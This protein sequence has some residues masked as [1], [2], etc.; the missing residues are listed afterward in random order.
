M[1]CR[2]SAIKVFRSPKTLFCFYINDAGRTC[3][4]SEHVGQGMFADEPGLCLHWP[5]RAAL[6][7]AGMLEKERSCSSTFTD[8]RRRE[9][10]PL[11][12]KGCECG[13]CPKR[14]RSASI[15]GSSVTS[16]DSSGSL[17]PTQKHR[18][19][20]HMHIHRHTHTHEQEDGF[21]KTQL[22]LLDVFGHQT[23][24][25]SYPPGDLC[26]KCKKPGFLDLCDGLID[27]N[28]CDVGMYFQCIGFRP[29]F[30]FSRR[31]CKVQKTPASKPFTYEIYQF[32]SVPTQ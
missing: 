26:K 24:P 5:S 27:G 30:H 15:S 18:A 28:R 8:L 4:K 25:V 29:S 20:G 21:K 1:V 22:S 13:H 14:S 19:A 17:P 31:R 12:K 7:K 10:C 32:K 16:A 2:L 3:Y 23:A 9:G 6:Q 11:V